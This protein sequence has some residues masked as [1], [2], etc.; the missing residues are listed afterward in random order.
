MYWNTPGAELFSALDNLETRRDKKRKNA[1]YAHLTFDCF[2]AIATADSDGE[3]V[4]CKK[5]HKLWHVID[6]SMLCVTILSGTTPAICHECP[7]F[8]GD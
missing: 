8:N 4:K 7:D 2:N 6:G 1:I 5:G 3:R